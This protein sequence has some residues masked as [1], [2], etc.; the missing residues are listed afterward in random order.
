MQVQNVKGVAPVPFRTKL[1]LIQVSNAVDDA[2]PAL[3][4]MKLG[5]VPMH[6]AKGDALPVRFQMRSVLMQVHNAQNVLQE[7]IQLK[8]VLLWTTRV[9]SAQVALAT[10]SLDHPNVLRTDCLLLISLV[11][12]PD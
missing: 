5:L 8:L 3:F 10:Q 9:S 12:V 7:D 11:L 4:Q 1:V 2:P 6:N